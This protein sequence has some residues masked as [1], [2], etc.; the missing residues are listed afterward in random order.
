MT[1][2]E[3]KFGCLSKSLDNFLSLSEEKRREKYGNNQAKYYERIVK[4]INE[5]F[6]DH[7]RAI[8]K[9][10][11]D[12]LNKIHF[13]SSYNAMLTL[14]RTKKWL[15]EPQDQTIIDARDYLHEVSHFLDYYSIEQLAKE[16][17]DN[18]LKWLNYMLNFDETVKK[19]SKLKGK[20]QKRTKKKRIS[21]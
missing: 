16:D 19:A 17:F 5:S 7:D 21:K 12:Y 8:L 11:K 13:L 4:S 14:L 6:D 1:E 9:L 2:S 3:G 15:A 20:K 10:P 18:T